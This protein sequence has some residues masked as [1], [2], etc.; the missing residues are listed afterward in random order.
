M[1]AVYRVLVASPAVERASTNLNVNYDL[2]LK[3]GSSMGQNLALASRHIE[4]QI[5][6]QQTL[7]E[8]GIKF[9]L[10]G[11]EVHYTGCFSL[12]ILKNSYSKLRCQSFHLIPFLYEIV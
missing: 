12:V 8:K 1:R 4:F 10:Y 9:K 11:D 3:F 7:N 2:H 6:R 5:A